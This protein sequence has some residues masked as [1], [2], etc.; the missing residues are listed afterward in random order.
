VGAFDVIAGQAGKLVPTKRAWARDG[1][2][3]TGT[4]ADPARDR[5]PPGQRLVRDWPG[6]WERNGYHNNADPWMEERY[7]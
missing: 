5:L 6:F 7:G 4:R 1:R 3:L 2:L